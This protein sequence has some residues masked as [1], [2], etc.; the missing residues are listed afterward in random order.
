[1]CRSMCVCG[2]VRAGWAVCSVGSLCAWYWQGLQYTNSIPA[3]GQPCSP[4][5]KG[6]C[7]LEMLTK[8][9]AEPPGVAMGAQKKCRLGGNCWVQ[10]HSKGAWI[11]PLAEHQVGVSAHNELLFFDALH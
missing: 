6:E 5:H 10:F 1:M 7:S 3:L 2:C 8:C 11:T 9:Q 4:G